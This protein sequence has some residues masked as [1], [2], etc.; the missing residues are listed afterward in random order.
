MKFVGR[1]GQFTPVVSNAGG[2]ILYRVAECKNHAAPGSKGYRW[3]ESELLDESNFDIID[4][5]FYESLINDA[6]DVISKYGDFEWFVSDD[7]YIP[8]PNFYINVPKWINDEEAP[9]A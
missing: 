7:P 4:K 2:G 9:F 3:I 5:S 8:D 1:V 6:V